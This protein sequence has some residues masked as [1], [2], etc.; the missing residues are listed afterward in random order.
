MT[1]KIEG[2]M[3]Q[4]SLM[5]SFSLVAC[6]LTPIEPHDYNQTFYYLSLILHSD[7][8]RLCIKYL[9]LLFYEYSI[10]PPP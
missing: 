8:R 1:G 10:Y 2:T 6:I 3:Q 5:G 9:K 7:L 4:V